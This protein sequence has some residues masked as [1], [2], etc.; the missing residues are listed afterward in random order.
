MDRVA[1]LSELPSNVAPGVASARGGDTL[2]ERAELWLRQDI[3][4]GDLAP[5]EP[6][7]VEA[8][9]ARYEIGATPLREALSRLVGEGLV[10]LRG[11]RGF[12]VRGLSAED[13][14]DIAL[15][16]TALDTP[17]IRLS[18]ERGGDAWEGKIVSTLHVLVRTTER[19]GTDR[20]SLD[21]WQGAHDAFHR[22]LV[23][24]CG[25]PRLLEAHDR[26]ALQHARYR[27]QLMGENM[28]RDLLI[29]EH[30]ELAD[31]ALA[32]DAERC[33]ALTARHMT[34]TSDFYARAL[35]GDEPPGAPD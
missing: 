3:V 21:A 13:L 5:N 2:S 6:L 20:E 34:L 14:T 4:S 9:R 31:A 33:E 35:P 24:A 25:S 15:M 23:G 1:V 32:R 19:T 8:L 17:G 7:R 30:R 29:R 26:L 16:R 27:R 10:A 18:I 11:N 12:T 22:A 28:P